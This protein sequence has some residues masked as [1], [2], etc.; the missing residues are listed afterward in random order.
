LLLFSPQFLNA[1]NPTLL[2]A[3]KDKAAVDKAWLGM[4]A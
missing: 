1:G 3:L 2:I 4:K